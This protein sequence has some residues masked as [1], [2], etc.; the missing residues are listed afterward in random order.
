MFFSAAR[1]STYN[2]TPAPQPVT[3]TATA[4]SSVNYDYTFLSTDGRKWQ[5]LQ[6]L[7]HQ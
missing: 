5:T 4:K 6:F 3:N 1:L 2:S 7:H